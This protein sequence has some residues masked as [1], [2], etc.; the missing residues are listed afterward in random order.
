MSLGPCNKASTVFVKLK[1][2]VIEIRLPTVE[3][4]LIKN[5]HEPVRVLN[6]EWLK[7]LLFSN[8]ISIPVR[9]EWIL[10]EHK[11]SQN[12]RAILDG[13]YKMLS[14]WVENETITENNRSS[15]YMGSISYSWIH[16]PVAMV[17]KFSGQSRCFMRRLSENSPSIDPA[18]KDKQE[19]KY[20]IE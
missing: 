20:K 9:Y 16:C 15:M 19:G 13:D 11:S 12:F 1:D 3:L 4:S 8:V 2:W 14:G 6:P 5:F 7:D 17:A 10:T 18:F